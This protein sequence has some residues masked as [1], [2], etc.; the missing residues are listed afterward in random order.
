MHC[1]LPSSIGGQ[2]RGILGPG[3]GG[4]L[5]DPLGQMLTKWDWKGQS[6]HMWQ[7]A[8]DCSVGTRGN[9]LCMKYLTQNSLEEKPSDKIILDEMKRV[10]FITPYNSS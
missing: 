6:R 5:R 8:G 2:G 1:I 9:H 4:W 10:Y 7:R 3:G